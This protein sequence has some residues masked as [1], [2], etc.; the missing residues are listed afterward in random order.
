MTA[1]HKGQLSIKCDLS[2][3]TAEHK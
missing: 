1:N 3:V 2:Q